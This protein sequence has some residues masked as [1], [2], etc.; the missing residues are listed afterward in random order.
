V[1]RTEEEDGVGVVVASDAS[2]AAGS[3][4][5]GAAAAGSDDAGAGAAGSDD[6]G[7]G[8]AGSAGADV[9]G[10]AVAVDGVAMAGVCFN[11]SSRG[12][13]RSL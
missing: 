4:D 9:E 3:D 1:Y 8:A 2:A 10:S 7:A 6:A 5:A 11:A 12:T 13:V